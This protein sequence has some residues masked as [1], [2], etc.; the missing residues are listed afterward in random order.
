MYALN[1]ILAPNSQ[2]VTGKFK[3]IGKDGK[4]GLLELPN[5]EGQW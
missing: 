3:Q 1:Q 4:D 5:S 2:A